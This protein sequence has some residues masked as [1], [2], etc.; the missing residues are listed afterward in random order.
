[1]AVVARGDYAING[2]A[3]DVYSFSGPDDLRQGDD[4]QFWT[5]AS[6]P[7]RFSGVSHLQTAAA[8]KSILDG[9]SK[10]YLVGEKYVDSGSYTNGESIGDNESLYAGYCTDL[11]RFTGAV[12]SVKYSLPPF[13]EPVSDFAVSSDGISA[14]ARFG[15]AHPG[16]FNMANCDGATLFLSFEIDP[17]IHLRSGHCRDEGRVLASL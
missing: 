9:A 16:G 4:I 7:T 2:G 8:L 5:G 6:V 14:A 11:H 13:A 12:E 10:T 1:V 3:S 15:S 17:E